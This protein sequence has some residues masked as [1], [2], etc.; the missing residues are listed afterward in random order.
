MEPCE[1]GL[2]HARLRFQCGCALNPSKLSSA[3]CTFSMISSASASGD[4]RSSKS[5][6][7]LCALPFIEA[8]NS[9]RVR[10]LHVEQHDVVNAVIVKFTH[11]TQIRSVFVR[12]KQV[13]DPRTRHDFPQTF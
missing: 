3:L 7:D 4:G 10:L 5:V 1:K 11:G 2:I 8:R 6:R 13:L 12:L 9:G